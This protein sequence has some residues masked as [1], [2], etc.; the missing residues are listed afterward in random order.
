M[1][2]I[3]VND[4]EFDLYIP[5]DQIE[6]AIKKLA[7]QLNRDMAGKNPLFLVV[8]NGAFMFAAELFKHLEIECE[9]SFVKLSSYLGTSSTHVVRELIGLDHSV[10]GRNIVLVEDIVDTGLTLRYTIDKLIKLEANEVKIATMLFKPK[11]FKYDYEV[12]YVG[13]EIPNDFII[14]YGLD[15][16]EHARN[17][18]DIYK[19]IS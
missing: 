13:I 16:N 10:H 5:Q 17:L 2:I 14:G 11:A 15:Y 3:R 19:V 12:D 18:P 1:S 6:R 4:K 9:I 8:L 7:D